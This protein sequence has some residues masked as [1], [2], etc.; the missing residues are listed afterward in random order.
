MDHCDVHSIFTSL[1]EKQDEA[2][3]LACQHLTSKQ[4]AKELGVAPVTIDKRIDAVRAK[5]DYMPRIEVLR[6]Y[7][8]WAERYDRTIDDP[9]ILTNSP[10]IA[11][12]TA[13]QPSERSY[14]FEDSLA[15]DARASWDRNSSWLQP[16][17]KPS[18]LG[19]GG[20]L[21]FIL[22]GAVAIM[23]VAVLSMAFANALG[24]MV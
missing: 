13:S 11:A 2:L 7:R 5:L 12:P 10:P 9:T 18:D 1:T 19:V 14:V 8:A 16:G 20:K 23:I 24:T 17:I 21:L 3:R 22:A 4:I 6:H 15:F